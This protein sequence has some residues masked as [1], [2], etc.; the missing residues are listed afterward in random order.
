MNK[1]VIFMNLNLL[2]N[3]KSK[4]QYMRELKN[5]CEKSDII[6]EVLDVRDPLGCRSRDLEAEIE[7]MNKKLVLVLN[8][9]DLVPLPVVYSWKKYLERE[10]PVVLFKANTQNQSTHLSTAKLFTNSLN[11][12]PELATKLLSSA[13]ALGP[14]KLLQLVKNYSKNDGVKTAVTVG[15]I[16]YPNVGKSSLIN[17]LKKRKA[18]AVSSTAGYTKNLQVIEID[19]QVKIIDS[20][21][22]LLTAEDEVNLILRNSINASDVK[23]PIEP[24]KEMLKRV[25]VEE[26]MKIYKIASF[27]NPTQFLLNVANSRGKFKKGGI[28]DIE[29]AARIVIGDWNSG[30]MN[31]YLPPPG[32]DPTVMLDFKEIEAEL[33]FDGED[34]QR[35]RESDDVVTGEYQNNGSEMMEE[36]D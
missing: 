5:V 17:S 30:K 25:N 9:I 20:P 6:L 2:G 24:I 11:T 29:A 18:A 8:K 3:Q 16:G 21:G 26:V 31:H 19:K 36:A 10:H 34:I 1:K 35:I 32:F 27:N 28:A 12:N 33:D 7:G 13:K 4:K 14:S 22:V 23:D 15:V